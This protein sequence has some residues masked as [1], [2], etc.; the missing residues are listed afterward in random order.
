MT[1]NF[2]IFRRNCPGAK[3]L[4]P[5]FGLMANIQIRYQRQYVLNQK[6]FYY[7]QMQ[8]YYAQ[9]IF[10]FKFAYNCTKLAFTFTNCYKYNKSNYAVIME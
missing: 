6:S 2:E 8:I 7:N 3:L 1:S 4:L 5:L 10:N 9:I